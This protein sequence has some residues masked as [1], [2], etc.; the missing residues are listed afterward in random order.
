MKNK[1]T[2]LEEKL[3]VK[4]KN[5]TLLKKALIHRSYLNEAK[6]K[7]LQS[8]ERLEFLGDAVLEL[9]T[10]Q[11]LFN[12]FPQ[13]PEGVLTNIRAALVC[14][15]SLARAAQKLGL[16]Q[17]L[18]LSRGEDKSGGRQNPSLLADTFEAVTGAIYLDQGWPQVQQFLDRHLL[19]KLIELGRSGDIKDAKTKLQEIIQAERRITPHYRILRE[20]G[21]DHA[22]IFTA[23][24]YFHDQ[25]IA[26]G[27]GQSKRA[28][29]E[30]AAQ[31]ALTLIKN[32]I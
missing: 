17:Y 3:G 25:Q 24:V 23:A 2:E 1:L 8:N 21:P 16:G 4:F 28:A 30:A 7:S 29:E 10:T 31:K 22:K 6:E 32:K 14:T 19:K 5:Q 20:E 9:W 15:E 12:R 18:Y 27:Q 26:L 11:E 13:L